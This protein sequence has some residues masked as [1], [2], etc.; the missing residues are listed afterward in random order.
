MHKYL[1]PA[2]WLLTA[3]LFWHDFYLWGGLNDLKGVGRALVA[4]AKFETPLASGYMFV[5]SQLNGLLGRSEKAQAKAALR[6]PQCVAHPERLEYMAVDQVLD[7]Q[8]AFDRLAYR[9]APL[10]LVL[11]LVAHWLR[12]KRIRSFG[13]RD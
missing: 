6:I 7:A 4:A 1:R 12:Q 9:G 2:M 8:G 10:L 3:W 13:M 11:S 5:G